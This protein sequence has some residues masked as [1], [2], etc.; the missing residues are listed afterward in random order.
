MD[1]ESIIHLKET[2][3]M[4]NIMEENL[5]QLRNKQQ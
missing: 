5:E 4:K 2:R 3:L 1:E